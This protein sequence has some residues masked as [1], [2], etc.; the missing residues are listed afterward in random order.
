MKRS[1]VAAGVAAAALVGAGGWYGWR[2]LSDAPIARQKASL[3]RS[4]E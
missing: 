1:I 4:L 2:A 3:S